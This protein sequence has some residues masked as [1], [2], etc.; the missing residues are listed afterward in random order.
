MVGVLKS[1]LENVLS[2]AEPIKNETIRSA[3]KTV[4]ET[5]A[6]YASIWAAQAI[7]RG[8]VSPHHLLDFVNHLPNGLVDD[9]LKRYCQLDF[10]S[11][12]EWQAKDLLAKGM[13]THHIRGVLDELIRIEELFRASET[14]ITDAQRELYHRLRHLVR[15]APWQAVVHCL[16]TDFSTPRGTS[17]LQI[18][19]DLLGCGNLQDDRVK[20]PLDQASLAKLRELLHGTYY[21]AVC[22]ETDQGGRLKANLACALALFGESGDLTLV[23]DLMERDIERYETQRRTFKEH[24]TS[25]SWFRWYVDAICQFGPDLAEGVLISLLENPYYGADAGHGLIKLLGHMKQGDTKAIWRPWPEMDFE[26]REQGL[27]YWGNDEKR[28]AYAASVLKAINSLREEQNRSKDQD[29]YAGRLKGMASVL[30]VLGESNTM[31]LILD[32]MALSGEWDNW[33]RVDTLGILVRNGFTLN[34]DAAARVLDPVISRVLER[35]VNQNEES[36]LGRCLCILLFTDK[37][38]QAVARLKELVSHIRSYDSI[39]GLF[40]ALGKCDCK[41]AIEYLITMGETQSIPDWA[42]DEFIHALAGSQF[43][44]AHD[45]LVRV[46]EPTSSEPRI[47]LTRR[48]LGDSVFARSTADLCRSDERIRHRILALCNNDLDEPQR[49]TLADVLNGLSDEESVLAGLHL[50]ADGTRDPIPFG[51]QQAIENRLFESIPVKDWPN[52]YEMRSTCDTVLRR[53]LFDMTLNDRRRCKSAL[54]LLGQIRLWRL[55]R[56]MPLLEPRHPYLEIGVPW[57]PP[58]SAM[59]R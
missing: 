23:K 28:R 30:A 44:E 27:A 29:R 1:E 26:R 48:N 14:R 16:I 9:L 38:C 3:I 10:T 56:G 33:A 18:I 21:A 19:L 13:E 24:H 46:L 50:M 43:P 15:M 59:P 25:T 8:Q 47:R 54:R 5:D 32:I 31:P 37:P 58:M 4:Y 49:S 12:D 34:Y 51:L 53:R 35:K 17:D 6:E 11:K 40:L 57:P 41:E 42:T 20:S 39:R 52:A 22:K 45:A 7:A 55:E 2:T 36:L